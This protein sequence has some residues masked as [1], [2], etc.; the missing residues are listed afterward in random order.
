MRFFALLMVVF[1]ANPLAAASEKP[2]PLGDP[3]RCLRVL[4]RLPCEVSDEVRFAGE[5]KDDRFVEVRVL[6]PKDSAATKRV[7]ACILGNPDYYVPRF[8]NSQ[9]S[10]GRVYVYVVRV[11]RY[12]CPE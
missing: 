7:A 9:S 12:F 8:L 10:K 1:T 2:I 3:K 5:I 11:R 4:A 6:P